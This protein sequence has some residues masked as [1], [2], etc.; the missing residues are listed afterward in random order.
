MKMPSLDQQ[1]I[2]DVGYSGYVHR[3]LLADIAQNPPN[4][5][6]FAAQANK[7]LA[8]PPCTGHKQP[9]ACS[10]Q[11]GST[12]F[13]S[14]KDNCGV[15]CSGCFHDVV[16]GTQAE[17]DFG[18]EIEID[19]DQKASLSCDLTFPFSNEGMVRAVT[20]KNFDVWHAP[21]VSGNTT[22]L[23][24]SIA[25]HDEATLMEPGAAPWYCFKDFPNIEVCARC[26]GMQ[27]VQA[28]AEDLFVPITRQLVPGRI[29]QCYMS[30]AKD[31]SCI[32]W[33]PMDYENT[34]A[35]R[36][37]YLRNVI[38]WCR[39]GGGDFT[40]AKEAAARIAALPPVSHYFVI[41]L[42]L[43]GSSK[44]YHQQADQYI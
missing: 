39:D 7:R 38:N 5:G 44:I 12:I 23:C 36:G 43:L 32:S 30:P 1:W 33:D 19:D 2:C 18:Y 31:P 3:T 29:R 13:R 22:A 15:F 17:R 40:M 9:I 42:I 16:V 11:Q 37:Q 35:W 24:P 20:A 26:Y 10:G 28:Q 27:M 14:V 34:T 6:H 21:I 41:C 8:M 4:F 25:G